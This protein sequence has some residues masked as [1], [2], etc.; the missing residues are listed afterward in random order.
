VE[1]GLPRNAVFEAQALAA[2]FVRHHFT[3]TVACRH[4]GE[5]HDRIG[6]EAGEHLRVGDEEA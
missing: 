5:I 3:G 4:A 2:P 6:V 1:N